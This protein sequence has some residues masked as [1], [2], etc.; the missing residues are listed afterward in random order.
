MFLSLMASEQVKEQFKETLF[1]SFLFKTI[2][3]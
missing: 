2:Q 3:K 1:N